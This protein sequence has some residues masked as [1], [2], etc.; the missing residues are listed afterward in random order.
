MWWSGGSWK[1]EVRDGTV[2]RILGYVMIG[3]SFS[4]DNVLEHGDADKKE[5]HNNVVS[6]V[7]ATAMNLDSRD[8]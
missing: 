4:V 5:W 6:A 3:Q 1:E 8:P 7:T 2:G